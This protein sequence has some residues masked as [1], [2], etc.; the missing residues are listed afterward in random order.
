MTSKVKYGLQFI[1][2]I[3]CVGSTIYQLTQQ[4]IEVYYLIITNGDK[5]CGNPFC[6]NWTIQQIS[7]QRMQVRFKI[8]K[9][10]NRQE[11]YNAAAIIGVPASRITFLGYE[12]SMLT[13]YPEQDPRRDIVTAIRSIR[14]DVVMSWYPYPNFAML[15]AQGISV[16]HTL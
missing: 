3:G 9:I 7:A 12:D 15:P 11:Q 4:N 6:A 8:Y 13:A 10:L 2:T 14:P 16:L 1:N 5:G